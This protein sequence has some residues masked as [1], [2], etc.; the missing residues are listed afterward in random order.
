MWKRIKI[1]LSS[2][3]KL[4][5]I[6]GTVNVNNVLNVLQNKL[7]PLRLNFK[8][9]IVIKTKGEYKM[10]NTEKAEHLFTYNTAFRVYCKFEADLKT[11]LEGYT[12]STTVTFIKNQQRRSMKL[13]KSNNQDDLA[14]VVVLQTRKNCFDQN[15]EAALINENVKKIYGLQRTN[16]KLNISREI[17]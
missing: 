16:W 8:L 11:W 2:L 9:C 17:H 10:L 12:R 4:C 6:Y 7:K 15:V 1:R 3:Q 13:N 14:Q 5:S